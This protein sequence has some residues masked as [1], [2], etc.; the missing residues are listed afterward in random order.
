MHSSL[1]LPATTGNDK[2]RSTKKGGF[3]WLS[4]L[5]QL[6]RPK[7]PL[8]EV[9]ELQE[10][11]S[12]AKAPT[13]DHGD[14]PQVTVPDVLEVMRMYKKFSIPSILSG[15]ELTDMV[16]VCDVTQYWVTEAQRDKLWEE[17]ATRLVDVINNGTADSTK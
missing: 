5:R 17:E 9:L 6:Q 14:L 7:T 16:N 1:P 12:G 10:T 8:N 11:Q 4:E 13:S 3:P 15:V 2:K